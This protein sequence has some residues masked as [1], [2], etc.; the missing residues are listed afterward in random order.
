MNEMEPY[1]FLLKKVVTSLVL[2]PGILI[3]ILLALILF[4]TKRL[5]TFL[6]VILLLVYVVSIEP[7]K[8]LFLRPLENAYPLPS[9]EQIQQADAIVVLGGG[10]LENAPDPDGP[11]VVSAD[12]LARLY[13]AYRAHSAIKKPI[14]ISAGQVFGRQPEAEVSRRV[15][16]KWGVAPQNVIVEIRSRDTAE[17]ALYTAEICQRKNWRKVV[18]V[19]SAYH[20]RRAVIL[21]NRHLREIVPYPTDYKTAR[22]SYDFGSF[23]P[24]ADNVADIAAATKEYIGIVFYKIASR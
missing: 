23:L 13:G 15:L 16:L 12:S 22:K 11:G 20:M 24:G 3:P 9:R 5:R 19:T 7:T 14:I 1:S 10:V 21:F 18:L 17:N 4:V 2:P 6:F 8:E